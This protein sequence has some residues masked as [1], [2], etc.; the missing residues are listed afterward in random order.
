MM[1]FETPLIPGTLIR[2]YKR[3]LAD[4]ELDDGREITAHCANPGA[5]LGLNMAGLRVWLEPNDN[6]K[7][8]L[9]FGWKLVELP[10]D[11]LAGI[12]TGVPNKVVGNALRAGRIAPLAAYETV[13]PEQ[14]YGQNSRIDF[15]LSQPGLPDAYV[16]VKN[17]HL[18]RAPG[19]A[20]FPDSVTARGAKH[21]DDLAEEA[22]RGNRAVML[23][24]IQRDDC[25]RLD[26]ARDLDPAYAA[27]FD[28]ARSRGV[29]ALAYRCSLSTSRITLERPVPIVG[30]DLD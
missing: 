26:L 14:K 5:M 20:E 16:E 9:K 10:G 15:L 13:R 17:V 3:F 19:L 29:E 21:L 23:Y 28:R 27:A 8:K 18:M 11:A 30:T 7:R 4:V 22:A 24:C 12:D 1:E 2:R 6:P 25:D